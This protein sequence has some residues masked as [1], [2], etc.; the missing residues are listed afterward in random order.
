MTKTVTMPVAELILDYDLYP[1][2]HIDTTNVTSISQ[3]IDAGEQLPP[4][5]A[6]LGSKRV[7]DGFHRVTA[8]LRQSPDSRIKVTLIDYPD[9]QTMFVD[10]V[11][12]NA[13]HGVKLSSFDRARTV[14]IG[15]R[16]SIDTERLAGALAVDVDVLAKL[17]AART[18]YD[19]SGKPVA[20]KRNARHLAGSKITERQERANRRAQGWPLS[21]HVDQ[22]INAIE[23][24]LVDWDDPRN[25]EAVARLREVLAAVPAA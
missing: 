20:I 8:Y 4:V 13:R 25:G 18:A 19:K 6:D 15:D 9:E 16:L 14:L 1:R 5:V 2:H 17:R 21:F 22:I 10:A 3:A 7:T 11:Q 23:G 12:R 24:D